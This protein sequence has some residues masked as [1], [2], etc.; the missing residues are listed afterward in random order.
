MIVKRAFDLVVA[1]VALVV[2]SPVMA[3]IAA[4]V[5]LTSPGPILYRGVRTGLH[6]RPFRIAKFRT[7]TVDAERYGVTTS[8][9][10][11]RVT[12]LGSFLRR[13]KLDELPQLLNVI[14]G[15]MSIVG[16][17]PEVAEH[18]NAYT[19]EER[20]I[21]TVRPGIT[22]YASIKYVALDEVVGS[23]N[24]HDFF[25]KKVRPDKNRLRLEYVRNQSFG[26]DLVIVARTVA[27]VMK[28]AVAPRR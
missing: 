7:M 11:P 18:T 15:D 23:E 9:G 14:A 24:A 8:L 27:V 16:P 5:R 12:R 17:R 21:L 28:K 1:S 26:E 3:G 4:A 22:D 10:D 25:I 20:A 6:G 19:D 2:L 13:Y